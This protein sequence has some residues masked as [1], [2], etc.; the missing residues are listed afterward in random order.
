[1]SDQD[2]L[3]NRTTISIVTDPELKRR[4]AEIAAAENRSM[5]A[6]AEVFITRALAEYGLKSPTETLP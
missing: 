1:M 3:P 4:L 2:T 6:Q 5:S